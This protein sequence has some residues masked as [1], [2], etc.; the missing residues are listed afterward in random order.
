MNIDDQVWGQV[1]S[2]V[3]HKIQ[4]QAGRHVWRQ[5]WDQMQE[6]HHEH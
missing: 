6:D 5:A 1:C 3:E 4:L 2:R